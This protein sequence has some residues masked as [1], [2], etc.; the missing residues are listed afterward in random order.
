MKILILVLFLNTSCGDNESRPCVRGQELQ[1]RCQAD[2]VSDYINLQQWMIDDCKR[3]Y[4]DN[5]CY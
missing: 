4:L 2:Y 3:R 5:V 1:L